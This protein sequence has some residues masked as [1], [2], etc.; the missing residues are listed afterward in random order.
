MMLNN[1]RKRFKGLG[2]LAIGF[3]SWLFGGPG[4]EARIASHYSYRDGDRRPCPGPYALL[5]GVARR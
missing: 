1:P 3:R 2:R 4:D 5:A